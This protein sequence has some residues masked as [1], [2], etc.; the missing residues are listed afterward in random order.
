[1]RK[2]LHLLMIL[3]LAT[4]TMNCST[5]SK[6]SNRPEETD[7]SSMVK[8]RRDDGTLSSINPVDEDGYV[9]GVKTNFYDDGKTIHS[10]IS[11]Q[12][13]RKHGP[14]LWYFRNGQTYEHTNF[15][16]GRK[17]GLTKRYYDT[18]ELMEELTYDT[19]E[20]MPGKK[21]YT[22]DGLLISN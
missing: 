9:H 4:G 19:G 3:L 6:K 21:K 22:K 18:G 16:Y 11:Y 14:A 1:M 5:D 7:K 10:K 13:G 15:I 2:P 20:E 8:K 17:N 12:H